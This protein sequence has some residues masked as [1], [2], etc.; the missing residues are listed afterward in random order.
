M[1]NS[2]DPDQ[3]APQ[4]PTDLDL[5]CL[6]RQ[7]MSCSAREGLSSIYGQVSLWTNQHCASGVLWPFRHL[8]VLKFY[9]PVNPMGS[10]QA[11]SDY[12]FTGQA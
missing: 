1:T 11:Q 9:G 2:A 4:K 7:G 5:H 3:L 8:F 10:C 12:L 6:L